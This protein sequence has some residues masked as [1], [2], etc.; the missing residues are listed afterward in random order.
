MQGCF[1]SSL[2]ILRQAETGERGQ[3]YSACFNYAIGLERLLKILLLLDHWH[4][5]REFPDFETLKQY[6]GK[7]GHNLE[8][9]YESARNLFPS[10]EVEWKPEYEPDSINRDLLTFLSDFANGSRY[11]NLDSLTGPTQYKDPIQRWEGLLYRVH[12]EDVR[13]EK[14]TPGKPYPNPERM[15]TPKLAAHH[16]RLIL[17]ARQITWRLVQLLLPLFELLIATREQVHKDDLRIGGEEAD[18]SVPYMEEFLD[19]VCGDKTVILES[20]DWP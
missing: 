13:N 4:R 20:E 8:K 15:E 16:V 1:K 10:Y 3:F 5:G 19:F 17:A 7:S 12:A 14:Q 9:L 6:G 11:F 18:P 2:R